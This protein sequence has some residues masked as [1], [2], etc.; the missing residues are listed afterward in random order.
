MKFSGDNNFRTSQLT[1]ANFRSS[2]L[3]IVGL[4]LVFFFSS[5]AWL[6]RRKIH[7]DQ[8][9]I[10]CKTYKNKVQGCDLFALKSP[11]VFFVCLLISSLLMAL[12][13]TP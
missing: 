7:L 2:A 8:I 4:R 6:A 9:C 11:S 1:Y 5:A 13:T 12:V 3:K 10:L